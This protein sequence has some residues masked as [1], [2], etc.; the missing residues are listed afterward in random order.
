MMEQWNNGR[1]GKTEYRRQNGMMEWW[2]NGMLGMPNNSFF[3][4]YHS[5]LPLFQYSIIP[6]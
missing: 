4:T 6:S 3:M 2:N 5:S 1:M